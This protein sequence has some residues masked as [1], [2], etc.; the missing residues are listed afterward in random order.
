M[1]DFLTAQLEDLLLDV[2]VKAAEDTQVKNI[3][4]FILTEIDAEEWGITLSMNQWAVLKAFYQLPLSIEEETFLES[5]KYSDYTR[6]T[7]QK[8]TSIPYQYLVLECGRRGSKCLNSKSV[9]YTKEYGMI[10]GEQLF[11]K[12]LLANHEAKNLSCGKSLLD[13]K[14][15]SL[16]ASFTVAVEGHE[17]TSSAKSFYIKGHSQTKKIITACNYEIEATPEHRIKV[18]DQSGNIV[19]RYFKD[20][21]AGEYAA[22]HRNINL[23]PDKYIK[24]EDYNST[25]Q[26][27]SQTHSMPIVYSGPLDKNWGRLLG[28]LV[29]DGS[30]N[31]LSGL[32]L[33][34]H[35]DDVPYFSKVLDKALDLQKQNLKI[36]EYT[37][38][39]LNRLGVRLS[40]FSTLLR[41]LFNNLGFVNQI[42]PSTK[43]IP[44]SICQSPK[45]VQ[46]AFLS[47]LF[48]AD[49]CCG[50][51]GRDVSLCT[52]SKFLA[53]EV[54]LMLLN[55]GIISKIDTREINE[56]NYYFVILQGQKSLKLFATEITFGL[57]RKQNLLMN[58]LAKTG[59]NG[60]N[61]EQIPY[62]KEWLKRLRDT[63]PTN[64]GLQPG[65][66]HA[67]GK[68]LGTDYTKDK[69]K[70]RNLRLEF[71]AIVG[72]AIKENCSENFNSCQLNALIEFAEEFCTADPEAIAHFKYLQIC[73][74]FY[75]PIVSVEDAEAFCVDLTVPGCEEYVAQGFTNHN[76][77]IAAVIIAYEF[78]KLCHVA[79]PQKKYNVAANTPITLL[80]LATTAD[81]AK[82]T[83]FA[84]VC[85]LFGFVKF[86]KVLISKGHIKICAEEIT[87]KSKLIN[88]KSGNSKS[89]S[90]VGFSIQ[91]L[92]MDEMARVEGTVGDGEDEE[93]NAISLWDNLGASGISFGKDAKRLALSSAWFEGDAIQE[94]YALAEV[95]PTYLG[96]RLCTWQLNPRFDRNN[97]I[98]ASAYIANPRKAALE[99]EGI[100]DGFNSGFFESEE[101]VRCFR[102]A[103]SIIAQPVSSD[104]T[105]QINLSFV[106]QFFGSSY[107]YL[108]PAVQK[109]SYT[110]VFGHKE[111]DSESKTFVF[112]DGI[113]VFKPTSLNK[114]SIVHVQD[115]IKQVHS[116]RS[117]IQLGVDHHNSAETSE[118]LTAHGIPVQIYP[119][120][121]TMQV[122]QYSTTREVMHENR[123]ILPKDS[124]WRAKAQDEL[125]RVLMVGPNKV[126]H[127]KGGCFIGSTLVRVAG[128]ESIT[129]Q[130]LA[131][132]PRHIRNG[133]SYNIKTNSQEIEP[134]MNARLTK[135]TDELVEVIFEDGQ[136]V[137]C[138]PE[139]LFLCVDNTYTEAQ[140]LTEKDLPKRVKLI[141]HLH[142]A[143]EVAV[144]DL[145][146]P[147][148]SNFKLNVGVF[149][150]NSKDIADAICGLTWL[151]LNKPNY[152]SHKP[153]IASSRNQPMQP[154]FVNVPSK[155]TAFSS[156]TKKLFA[157]Y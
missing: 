115:I 87:Y 84:Q 73:G 127:P 136:S 132:S 69:L 4:D 109:D 50:K 90:Q 125:C 46:A 56:K 140:K 77:A 126:D 16:P 152:A 88:V 110:F 74:Y 61:T 103:S 93:A 64:R 146:M 108:D 48:D 18:L 66:S 49:G 86:F 67:A 100:R 31:S 78:Y 28:L 55:F 106:E 76:T 10:S 112:V 85:G 53:Q 130:E 59:K 119:A 71:R 120:S 9:I 51:K 13:L 63:L 40:V 30:W 118:R 12:I 15:L 145:E 38:K 82:G 81:Q 155:R 122:T 102:G 114:V 20:I 99:Y 6:T 58:H 1:A 96:F 137:T 27:V 37:D 39:R 101:V 3:V 42:T 150:H 80:I 129:I 11:N 65:S 135:Y 139:H 143:K 2:Q 34:S 47:G 121:N 45:D 147:Q 5:L 26:Y 157:R 97:P 116:K 113:L 24:L 134:M 7:W 35:K 21:Q 95:D 83:I 89:S 142:L 57:L 133:Y 75:D 36:N 17:E 154:G 123:L 62:Q 94:L 105:N 23:F 111:I 19:W 149:V 22:I 68:L 117:L 52:A 70:L 124:H 131:E 32:Q 44:W 33:S 79:H 144:Y 43:K 153:V 107:G 91:L 141:K 156:S 8:S 41:D 151:L 72:N 148:N 138:T 98:I 54:Q 128:G 14:D 104:L 60:G 29:G 25:K 92:V